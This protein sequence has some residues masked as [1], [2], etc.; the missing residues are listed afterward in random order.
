MHRGRTVSRWL[1][2]A[3]A[4]LALVAAVGLAFCQYN[5]TSAPQVRVLSAGPNAVWFAHRW[6]EKEQADDADST[7]VLLTWR[8]YRTAQSKRNG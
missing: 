6:V 1:L 5:Y 2:I 7:S 4:A 3:I 8:Q